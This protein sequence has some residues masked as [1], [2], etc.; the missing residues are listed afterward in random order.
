[1]DRPSPRFY[2]LTQYFVIRELLMYFLAFAPLGMDRHQNA[3]HP[4]E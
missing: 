3:A 2:V 4:V 1:M